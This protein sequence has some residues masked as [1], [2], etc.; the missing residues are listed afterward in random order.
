MKLFVAHRQLN[1]QFKKSKKRLP[2]HLV[3]KIKKNTHLINEE[4]ANQIRTEINDYLEKNI[5]PRMHHNR[6]QQLFLAQ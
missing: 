4:A 5:T 6:S 2:S 3:K 1:K